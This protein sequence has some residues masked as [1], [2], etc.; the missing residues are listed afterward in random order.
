MGHSSSVSLGDCCLFY[1]SVLSVTVWI[2]RETATSTVEARGSSQKV[3]ERRSQEDE[4]DRDQQ[5]KKPGPGPGPSQDPELL[6]CAVPVDQKILSTHPPPSVTAQ[7]PRPRKV[8]LR[9]SLAADPEE[10]D[11]LQS[12]ILHVHDDGSSRPSQGIAR[13]DEQDNSSRKHSFTLFRNESRSVQR[14]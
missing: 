6:L 4:E 3:D 14:A 10:N 12:S 13:L 7:T 5:K 8:S 2:P 9:S 11:R 1:N